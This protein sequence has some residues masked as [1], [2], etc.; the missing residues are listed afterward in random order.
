[1]KIPHP[2]TKTIPSLLGL[3]LL[4]LVMTAGVFITSRPINLLTKASQSCLP[5]N[6][7][8]TNLTYD[9]FDISFITSKKCQVTCV[10]NDQVYQDARKGLDNSITHYFQIKS[11]QPGTTYQ[12]KFLAEGS[13]YDHQSYQI[14]TFSKPSSTQ[15][16]ASLSWGRV[17]FSQNQP[18]LNSIV[19][20][21]IPGLYPLSAFVTDQAYWNI[22]LTYSYSV[23]T[24]TWLQPPT[25]SLDEIAIM[26]PDGQI[27]VLTNDSLQKNPVPDIYLDDQ[28]FA[29]SGQIE[30]SKLDQSSD[31]FGQ[32]L[33]ITNP[34]DKEAINSQMPSFFGQGP[35]GTSVQI[36]INSSNT[37]T[38]SFTVNADGT[39]QWVTPTSLE[40]GQHTVT[41]KYT[42]P[43]SNVLKTITRSFT[44]LAQ[45]DSGLP[46]F[47]A[48]Q[49]ANLTSPTPTYL[50]TQT[51]TTVLVPTSTIQP[52]L[53]PSPTQVPTTAPASPTPTLVVSGGVVPTI[54]IL[55]IAI[56][57]VASSI[58]FLSY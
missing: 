32:P 30:F 15:I 13:Q 24:N 33:T 17:Y 25:N 46:A 27:I 28:T 18:A 31:S 47:S 39:W 54:S 35:A 48:S 19:Y 41:L 14:T 16:N 44:V 58:I 52:T 42:D 21:N 49:S 56:F 38:D 43:V 55:I 26:S 57:L 29:Q 5:V 50:P 37:I 9:S 51:P 36:E 10:V 11:L 4:L 7:Q 40:P 23:D 1:M 3:V 2:K 12:Y 53:A 34:T 20:I 8:I 22:P 6:V 45:S